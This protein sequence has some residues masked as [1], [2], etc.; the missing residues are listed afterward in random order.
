MTD[1]QYLNIKVGGHIKNCG[2]INW[3]HHSYISKRFKEHQ[4]HKF[5][6]GFGMSVVILDYLR[7]KGIETV[8]VVFLGQFLKATVSD[9][10][11]KGVIYRDGNDVQS[12]LGLSEFRITENIE[13]K[14]EKLV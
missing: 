9:F 3:K 1:R 11:E 10:Y 12:I 7:E 5:G 8:I 6:E 4:F 13:E 14:Q 2:F